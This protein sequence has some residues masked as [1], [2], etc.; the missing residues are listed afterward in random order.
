M[1]YKALVTFVTFFVYFN[2][3]AQQTKKYK[4]YFEA[5]KH[6]LRRSEKSKLVSFIEEYK[7][8]IKHVSFVG[9]CD[10]N[11]NSDYNLSLSKKRAVEVKEF[12]YKLL[13]NKIPYSLKYKGELGLVKSKNIEDQRKENRR[14]EITCVLFD[15]AKTK[16][17]LVAK[18]STDKPKVKGMN[19]HDFLNY[20]AEYEPGVKRERIQFAQKQ[21]Q[22]D[23]ISKI[24]TEEEIKEFEQ[25]FFNTKIGR[26]LPTELRYHI[27][28]DKYSR[29][30]TK[31]LLKVDSRKK[32]KLLSIL[33]KKHPKLKVKLYTYR[34]KEMKFKRIKHNKEAKKYS[35]YILSQK[36][37]LAMKYL[38]TEGITKNRLSIESELVKKLKFNASN[39]DRS[40]EVTEIIRLN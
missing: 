30:N 8:K 12:A 10:D 19:Y 5:N 2:L 29:Y 20:V 25:E 35:N 16:S 1:N 7:S 15:D 3:V 32:L 21:K 40:P 27:L 14:V 31:V 37:L 18:E 38:T 9:Y 39:I 22:L 24:V 33:M 11:A 4:V 13:N 17:K 28:R 6:E 23:S 34:F 26:S 36:V